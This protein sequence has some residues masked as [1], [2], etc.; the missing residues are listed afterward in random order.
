[1]KKFSNILL[2]AL[3][4]LLLVSC[5]EDT[6]WKKYEEWRNDQDEWLKSQLA[7][8]DAN[9][10][11][12]FETVAASFDKNAVV[13]IHYHN[14]REATKNNLVPL[15]TSVV[16]V[17]YHGRL[18]NDVPFDSSYL[19]T[20]PAD[21]VLRFSQSGLITGWVIA[22]ENMHV[23]DSITVIVPWNVGYGEGSK[24]DVIKPY[25]HLIFDMKLKDIYKYEAKP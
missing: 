5:L 1:M 7:R 4:S 17:K 21:S 25:S 9:G 10:D 20:S 13:Y 8:T 18:Y 16:D 11:K 14:D 15:Y 19:S 12:Y 22:L 2:I 24:G 6:D 3:A 23:G